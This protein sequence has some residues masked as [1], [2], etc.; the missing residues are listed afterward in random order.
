MEGLL[1][2]KRID[3]H[4]L[5]ENEY[6]KIQGLARTPIQAQRVS[7]KRTQTNGQSNCL[8][9]KENGVEITHKI[10]E[11]MKNKITIKKIEMNKSYNFP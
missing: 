11:C 4:Q 5:Q 2:Q 6:C 10:E 7:G 1:K 8:N 3:H 9:Q